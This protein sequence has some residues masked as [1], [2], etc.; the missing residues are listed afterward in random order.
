MALIDDI[1]SLP[2][3][4]AE[5]TANHLRHHRVIHSA[6]KSNTQRLTD[7]EFSAENAEDRATSAENKV[8]ANTARVVALEAMN[9]VSPATPVDGQTANLIAQQTTL[10]RSIINSLFEED[11]PGSGLFKHPGLE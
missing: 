2:V 10:T 1:N 4:V 3:S 6:L 9:G 11:P 7:V 8:D 5:N